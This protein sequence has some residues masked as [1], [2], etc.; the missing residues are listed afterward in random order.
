MKVTIVGTGR[1]GRAI[2]S[3]A[4]AGG[5]EVEFIATYISKAQELADK[6]M[7]EGSVQAADLVQG[8]LVVLAVRYTEAPHV[9]RQ[10]SDQLNGKV[11][12][13]PTNP[14]DFSIVEPLDGDWLGTFRSGGE[15]IEAETPAEAA[16]V[17]AFNTNFAGP[18]YAGTLDGSPLDAFVAG[19]DQTAK[20][21]IMRLA[22][23]G[24]L[25][26][27]D[28]GRLRRSRELEALALLHMEIQG[29]RDT[30][31]ASA[32]KVVP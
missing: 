17:K 31:F 32:I 19:D 23:D 3:R 8:D 16:F 12:V 1:M 15:L 11:I 5:H 2:A 25:R 22:S 29:S 28:A 10:Y 18:L 4:V 26:A 9:V 20:N 6:M 14:V 27:I 30:P 13:D 7:G 24:S 21:T